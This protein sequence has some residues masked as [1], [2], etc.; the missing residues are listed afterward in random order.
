MFPQQLELACLQH[1]NFRFAMVSQYTFLNA[2]DRDRSNEVWAVM[3]SRISEY[4]LR[5]STLD[6]EK[7]FTPDLVK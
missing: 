6:R 1:R 5:T 4:R 2:W 7:A 3:V